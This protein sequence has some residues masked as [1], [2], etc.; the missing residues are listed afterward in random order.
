MTTEEKNTRTAESIRMQELVDLRGEHSRVF[1]MSDGTEQAVF[2][3]AG[4]VQNED[5]SNEESETGEATLLAAAD[6]AVM[7]TAAADG[8][9]DGGGDPSTVV[10]DSASLTVYAWADG[11]MSESGTPGV[12]LQTDGTVTRAYFHVALPILPRNPRIKKA[13]LRLTQTAAAVTGETAPLLGLYPL[14]GAIETGSCTPTEEALPLDYDRISTEEG[15]VY[16]FDVTALMDGLYKN[17]TAIRELALRLMDE[18]AGGG[19]CSLSAPELCFDYEAGFAVNNAYRAH[20]HDLGRFGQAR[21]DLARGSLTVESED[22]A[23][24]GSRLP[25]TI[26]HLYNSAYGGWAFSGNPNIKLYAGYH[27]P[28]HIGYGWK[29]N[30]MQ[31]MVPASFCYE[32]VSYSGYVH[33]NDAGEEFYFKPEPKDTTGNRYVCVTDEDM[34]YDKSG[35]T[36]SVGED[37]YLFDGFGR[38]I[39]ITDSH[40]NRMDMTYVD[41]RLQTVSDGSGRAFTFTYDGEGFLTALTAPDGAQIT[42]TYDGNYL[43]T[44]TYPTGEQVLLTTLYERIANVR[45]KDAA[46][47]VRYRV[48]YAYENGR[49]ITAREY[50]YT[51]GVETA[52]VE[53]AYTYAI[54]G[55][56][57]RLETVEPAGDGG[58]TVTV[59]TVYAFDDDGGV[60]G[61]YTYAQDGNAVGVNGE[62]GQIHPYAGDGVTTAAGHTGYLPKT[63]NSLSLW[64]CPPRSW[65]TA[66]AP[67]TGSG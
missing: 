15:T 56:H 28:M 13:E 42:Y 51:D 38:L 7:L 26:K 37:S 27:Y 8:T 16:A 58:V 47:Q 25:V 66:A 31:S 5:V 30:V 35:K 14:T 67:P 50:G 39:S 29:L 18:T 21:V 61:A 19:L 22:F 55:R 57:T 63:V 32:G 43:R 49:L 17:N 9:E 41:H 44:I 62:G 65:R 23:W 4:S 45:L 12:G 6:T 48:Q 34:R 3:P 24:G 54:A 33:M 46:G 59:K 2:Y 64:I 60:V 53:N 20:T 40:E 1:L 11:V 36:M 10:E 52:G